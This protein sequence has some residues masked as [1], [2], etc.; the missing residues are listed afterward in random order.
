M[1]ELERIHDGE[2]VEGGYVYTESGLPVFVERDHE[3]I[4]SEVARL[5]ARDGETRLHLAAVLTAVSD[6]RIYGESSLKRF[7]DENGVTYEVGQKLVTMYRRISDTSRISAQRIT[8]AITSGTLSTY[9]VNVAAPIEDDDLFAELLAK[10]E[11]ERIPVSGFGA[12]V[13]RARRAAAEGRQAPEEADAERAG[14]PGLGA[15]T[16]DPYEEASRR[17]R[18]LMRRA[19]ELASGAQEDGVAEIM[20]RYWPERNRRVIASEARELSDAFARLADQLEQ[21]READESEA[22]ERMEMC[23]ECGGSGRVWIRVPVRR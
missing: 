21:A 6:E 20:T 5:R 13:K 11:D 16:P 18:N 23:H 15:E 7:C 10:A 9:H 8:N 12:E 1:M 17:W 14:S 19:H 3:S 22:V 2:V 4:V